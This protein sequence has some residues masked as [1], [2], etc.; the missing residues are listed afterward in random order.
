MC[1]CEPNNLVFSSID[2]DAL[3]FFAIHMFFA[4]LYSELVH[5]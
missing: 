4:D 2:P 1:S 5:V 3:Q